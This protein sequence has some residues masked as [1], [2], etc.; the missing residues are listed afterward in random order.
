MVEAVKE[1]IYNIPLRDAKRAP[2]W[3]RS[4]VAIKDIRTFL[5]KHMKAEDVKLDRNI[6]EKVWERGS[7]KPPRMIRVRAMKFS[8]GQVQAELAGE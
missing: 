2:K 7:Q 6:N 4:K 3:K 8:D 5:E 1:Q